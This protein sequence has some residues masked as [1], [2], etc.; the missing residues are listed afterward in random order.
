MEINALSIMIYDPVANFETHPLVS[1]SGVVIKFNVPRH[2]LRKYGRLLRI[3][4]KKEEI[5]GNI[6]YWGLLMIKWKF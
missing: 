6:E 3:G 1:P 4:L 2:Y 5:Q